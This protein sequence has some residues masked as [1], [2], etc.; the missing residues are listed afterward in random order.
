MPLN[1]QTHC[2][3][4]PLNAPRFNFYVTSMRVPH[5]LYGSIDWRIYCCDI[6][7]YNSN[8]AILSGGTDIL[9]QIMSYLWVDS[10]RRNTV[11]TAVHQ[12]DGICLFFEEVSLRSHPNYTPIKHMPRERDDLPSLPTTGTT[13]C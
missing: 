4:L 7:H 6:A 8:L 12:I 9:H 2:H 13:P 1:R 11:K 10:Q 5:L 3:T